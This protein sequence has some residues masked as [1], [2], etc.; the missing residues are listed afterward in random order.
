MSHASSL[1]RS[2]VDA[3]E[4]RM[5][6]ALQRLNG[7]DDASKRLGTAYSNVNRSKIAAKQAAEADAGVVKLEPW[8]EDMLR[9]KT[10]SVPTS[11]LDRAV[12]V[13]KVGVGPR[14]APPPPIAF[15]P[16]RKTGEELRQEHGEYARPM[17]PPG[18]P[19]RSSDEKKDELARANQMAGM[20]MEEM[21]RQRKAESIAADRRV[22]A[23]GAAA[24]PLSEKEQVAKL[25]ADIAD[26]IADRQGF[27]NQMASAGRSRE[28]EAQVNGEIAD[29]MNDLRRL[30]VLSTDKD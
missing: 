13:P 27:L 23:G 15:V 9:R 28:Y 3:D 18:V 2:F 14:R 6:K 17:A 21:T 8:Q 11:V 30:Y 24:A 29:R 19:V 25:R 26:E 22:G 1:R 20:S 16:H 4:A 12:R 10:H 7:G 5:Q